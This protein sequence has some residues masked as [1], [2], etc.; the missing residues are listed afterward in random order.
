MKLVTIYLKKYINDNLYAIICII[1][2]LYIFNIKL[3]ILYKCA[4]SVNI[5]DKICL[6]IKF[7]I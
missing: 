6:I 1:T 5:S 7:Y 4:C 3:N 2:K